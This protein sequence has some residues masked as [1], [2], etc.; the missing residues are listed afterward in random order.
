MVLSFKRPVIMNG[1]TE[2]ITRGDL[3]DR[4]MMVTLRAIPESA[5]KPEDVIWTAYDAA[6]PRLLGA[7][8]HAISAAIRNRDMPRPARVPRMADFAI[9]VE[10]AAPQ[11]GWQ[12]GAFID[13]YRRMRDDTSGALIE[14]SPIAQTVLN[15]ARDEKRWVGTADELLS[16]LNRKV[17]AADRPKGWPGTARALGDALRRL[18]PP[19]HAA[20][21]SLEFA[22]TKHA[23]LWTITVT[24]GDAEVTKGDDVESS[25][26]TRSAPLDTDN[27]PKGDEGDA[28]LP[29]S[30]VQD[31]G[32]GEEQV[33]TGE[34][35]RSE[36][37]ASPSS[38][39]SPS[40]DYLPE[41]VPSMI[42]RLK[43]REVTP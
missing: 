33:K 4:T 10:R 27:T 11:L 20:G 2:F 28:E 36:K 14:A 1:I 38:P 17:D 41:Y 9:W 6:R 37:Y 23:R 16:Q 8:L 31:K 15:F 13:A 5:R 3:A 42:E 7:L 32:K 30:S 43:D 39:S 19:A 21:V 22:R 24:K 34:K 40:H 26:V 35:Q 25:F 18:A 29:T 12:P